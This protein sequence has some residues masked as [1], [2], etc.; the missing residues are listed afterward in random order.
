MKKRILPFSSFVCLIIILASGC[1]SGVD[2][3]VENT[4]N[5]SP[6]ESP[7]TIEYSV[8]ELY[9]DLTANPTFL[10]GVW[11]STCFANSQNNSFNKI[12]RIYHLNGVFREVASF[13]DIN[14]TIR[15]SRNTVRLFGS[16][17]NIESLQLFNGEENIEVE[18][19]TSDLLAAPIRGFSIPL[20]NLTL[21]DLNS[22]STT[23]EVFSIVANRLYV[24][25]DFGPNSYALLNNSDTYLIN[26][27]IN[28]DGKTETE[29]DQL[30]I[31]LFNPNEEN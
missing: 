12:R 6:S 15:N 27:T 1:S 7:K 18:K 20:Q 22:H 26:D 25:D 8:I 16:I 17:S 2:K 3:N 19:I 14:C 9:A 5:D 21:E 13:N 31:D 29:I 11:E 24:S 30:A 10:E 4:E 28:T 23:V